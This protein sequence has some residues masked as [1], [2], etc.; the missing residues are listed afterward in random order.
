M[1]VAKDPAFPARYWNPENGDE[2]VVANSSADVPEGWMDHHPANHEKVMKEKAASAPKA[3]E[4]SM[5]R[6]EA[7]AALDEGGVPYAKNA[8]HKALLELLDGKLRESLKGADIAFPAE[9]STKEL[10]ELL[11][12]GP[13]Q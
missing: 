9:A 12:A 7:K 10:Y 11:K 1:N 8:G 6:D 3:A 4:L 13:A 2:H 5:T